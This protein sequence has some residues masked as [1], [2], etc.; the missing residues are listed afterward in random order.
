MR[1]RISDSKCNTHTYEFTESR[2][3]I[4]EQ[5]G[6]L[7]PADAKKVVTLTVMSIISTVHFVFARCCVCNETDKGKIALNEG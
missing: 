6:I 4:C 3:S 7:R 1:E 2:V 5:A